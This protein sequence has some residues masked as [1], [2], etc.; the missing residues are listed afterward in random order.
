MSSFR[1]LSN[2]RDKSNEGTSS[3]GVCFDTCHT[4]VAGYDLRTENGVN[5][6]FHK[7]RSEVGLRNLKVVHPNDSKYKSNSYRDRWV[8]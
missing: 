4:F 8:R 6:T 7:L 2:R 1:S 5:E 3:Y